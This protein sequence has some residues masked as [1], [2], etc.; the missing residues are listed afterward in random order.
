MLMLM[1]VCAGV[2]FVTGCS[3]ERADSGATDIPPALARLGLRSTDGVWQAA[4]GDAPSRMSRASSGYGPTYR[5]V[6]RHADGDRLVCLQYPGLELFGTP[7]NVYIFDREFNLIREGEIT[8]QQNDTPY[9]I[10]LIRTPDEQLPEPLRNRWLLAVGLW[11]NHFQDGASAMFA[12]RDGAPTAF[13]DEEYGFYFEL[14]H[15]KDA[16]VKPE[17][18]SGNLYRVEQLEVRWVEPGENLQ[19]N[20][21]RDAERPNDH[22]LPRAYVEP[23]LAGWLRS[24]D[25]ARIKNTAGMISVAGVRSPAV[26]AQVTREL[27]RLLKHKDLWVR[28]AAC[29]ALVK[30]E[31][32]AAAPYLAQIVA[33]PR[34]AMPN[35]DPDADES[36][37]DEYY[38][39]E[40]DLY[41]YATLALLL[42]RD[43]QWI[44]AITAGC[45]A[46]SDNGDAKALVWA[47]E[48]WGDPRLAPALAQF[49]HSD[50]H[51][52]ANRYGW[53]EDM[54]VDD[55]YQRWGT[56]AL[57]ARRVLHD[58]TGAWF[59]FNKAAALE[60]WRKVH[61]LPATERTTALNDRFGPRIE[62]QAK[63]EY[64]SSGLHLVVRNPNRHPVQLARRPAWVEWYSGEKYDDFRST[65]PDD[66]TRA[67]FITLP[68]N[69]THRVSFKDTNDLPTPL[70]VK[71]IWTQPG[72]R[73]GLNAWQGRVT[74][75]VE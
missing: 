24:A 21:E 47:I 42:I 64:D 33:T 25:G 50:K 58:I 41:V 67:S 1:G 12:L 11:N 9:C 27:I 28:L 70:T 3:S 44:D 39:A 13:D 52:Q 72:R 15:W 59:P 29:H 56:A 53:W 55:H 7:Y 5:T 54:I 62:L 8:A 45:A 23:R 20:A 18:G 17:P 68:P 37:L 32:P 61:T 69:G 22:H 43:A 63:A 57:Q 6:W 38:F 74:A 16:K 48:R 75:T 51:F 65:E 60:T 19:V 31:G 73:F 30:L 10:A 34:K 46:V 66:E 2:A 26:R 35:I 36:E 4:R 71:A 40:E 49:L 14:P